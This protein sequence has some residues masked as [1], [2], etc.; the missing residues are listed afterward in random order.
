MNPIN[1]NPRTGKGM[2]G[3]FDL[4]MFHLGEKEGAPLWNNGSRHMSNDSTSFQA[5]HLYVCYRK[6]TETFTGNQAE[7]IK[8]ELC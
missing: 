3:S 1:I 8:V 6:Q 2:Y 5:E 7:L 4:N